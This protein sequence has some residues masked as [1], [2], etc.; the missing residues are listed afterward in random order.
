MREEN[1]GKTRGGQ[2]QGNTLLFYKKGEKFL[3]KFNSFIIRAITL[4]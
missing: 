3:I 2:E 4:L 1:K